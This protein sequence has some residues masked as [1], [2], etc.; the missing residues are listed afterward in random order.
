M[1]SSIFPHSTLRVGVNHKELLEEE[2]KE[3][4]EEDTA[5]EKCPN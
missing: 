2:D 5:G 4:K 3:D 1:Q